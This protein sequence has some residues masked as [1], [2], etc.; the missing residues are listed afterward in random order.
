VIRRPTAILAL[1]TALNLVNYLDR[2]VLSAVLKPLEEDLQLTTAVSGALGTVFLLSFFVTSPF[3]GLLADR[4]RRGG[5][6]ALMGAGIAIWSLA[7]LSSGLA[8]TASGLFVSRALV[9]VGEASYT[10]IAPTLIDDVAPPEKRGSWLGIFYSAIPLGSA[11]GFIVGGAILSITHSWRNAFFVA[12]GPGLLLAALCLTVD[13]PERKAIAERPRLLSSARELLPI[14]LFRKTTL[15][16]CAQTFGI[17]GFGYW[18]P[19]YISERYG[20]EQGRASLLFGALTLFSGAVGTLLGGKVGDWV[21]GRSG[22]GEVVRA[23]L[24][25][26]AIAMAVAAPLA[27]FAVLAPT[28]TGFFAA[29]LPCEAALFFVTGPANFALLRSVATELRGRAMAFNIF[30]IHA[31]GDLWSP[32]LIGKLATYAPMR[33]AML[34]CPAAFA[35]AA[36]VWWERYTPP[37]REG[38]QKQHD[39]ALPAG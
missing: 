32:L 8:A 15:G 30:A 13:E 12:G 18:A 3:F 34:L 4:A 1:L 17:G 20:M 39:E 22:E 10:A 26:S 31:L 11:L 6:S 21:T 16:M 36:L 19:H 24:A 38:P 27:L 7:T 35:L 2:W 28:A 5:R 14:R 37:R 25:V 33:W 9:G 29:V 23:N